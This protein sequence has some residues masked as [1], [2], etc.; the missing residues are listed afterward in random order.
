MNILGIIPARGGSKRI[1]KKNSKLFLGNPIIQYPIKTALNTNLFTDLIVST[2]CNEIK[3]ISIASGAKVPFMRPPELSD[4]FTST[5]PVI[6]HALNWMELNL[7]KKYDYICCIYATTPL[8]RP[9]FLIE[10]FNLLKRKNASAVFA[11]TEYEHS[12]F[13]A[14]KINKNGFLE[15]YW[16]ENQMKRSNDLENAYH[17]AGQFYWLETKS[18]M[19]FNN[20]WPPESLPYLLPRSLAQDI[21]TEEDWSLLEKIYR[22]P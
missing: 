17:D 20:M 21:D 12:I 19:K 13:R 3:R 15:M 4:D 22:N 9:N 10:S 2:D 1:P 16:P 18:F 14:L 7:N 11:V 8:L 5:A 6:I